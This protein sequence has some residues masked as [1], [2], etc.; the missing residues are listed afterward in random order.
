MKSTTL[1]NAA[2]L[3]LTSQLGI[4]GAVCLDPKTGISGHKT[5]LDSEIGAANAIIVGRVLEEKGLKED[6]TDPDG[7]TAYI[8]TI[9]VL[10]QLKGRLPT[11]ISIR[12]ENTSAR[13]GMSA[14]E[15]HILF[16]S[17]NRDGL[18]WVNSCGNSAIVSASRDLAKKIK[19]KLR[20]Q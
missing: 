19:S 1:L 4:A 17:Q 6:V 11:M 5:V 7:V 20:K 3:C 2:F 8:V 16:V 14:G 15:E 13:Y 18:L 9:K 12:N 10:T